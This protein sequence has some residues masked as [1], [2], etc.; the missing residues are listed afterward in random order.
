MCF[1]MTADLVVGTALAPVAVLTLREVRH[2]RE[3]PFAALPAVFALHQFLEVAVWAG[4]DG[5]VPA[6]VAELAMR[7]YL[8]IA[9]PLLPIYVPLAVLMLEPRRFRRRITPFVALGAVVAAYLAFVVL[10]NPVEVIRHPNGLEYA[11]QVH[12]PI[13]WAVLYVVAV[14]GPALLSGYRSIV[15]FGALNLVGL[16][17]VAVFY[18]QEFASLWCIFAAVS[19]ILILVHM[20]RRRRLSDAERLHGELLPAK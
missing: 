5:D 4:L 17:L 14:I 10:A 18:F 13:V 2:R 3:L 20:V 16:T 8:F 15:A 1:S 6:G 11:T 12:H 9:W 19:S 7:A